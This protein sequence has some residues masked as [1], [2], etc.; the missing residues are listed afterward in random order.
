MSDEMLS[1]LLVEARDFNL[2]HDITGL[3]LYGREHFYQ[4]LEGGMLNVGNLFGRIRRDKRHLDVT[5]IAERDIETR[6]FSNWWMG[7]QKLA[8]TNLENEPVFHEVRDAG[9][10]VTLPGQGDALF[11]VMSAIYGSY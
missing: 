7:F 6:A 1:E 8:S 10:L 11:E 4:I 2:E 9:D 5:L 3:L